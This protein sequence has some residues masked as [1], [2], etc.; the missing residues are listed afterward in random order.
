MSKEQILEL[1]KTFITTNG[2]VSNLWK[3]NIFTSPQFQALMSFGCVYK[4]ESN[5]EA[6]YV[7]DE[8]KKLG[9]RYTGN[10]LVGAGSMHVFIS[11][12]I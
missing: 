5:N 2:G 7:R 10:T 12:F 6:Q 3:C 9:V 4:C 11:V 8:L 1:I